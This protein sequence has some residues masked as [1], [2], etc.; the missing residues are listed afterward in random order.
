MEPRHPASVVQH[1][2]EE[3]RRPGEKPVELVDVDLVRRTKSGD[4]GAFEEL[5]N[6]Y[7][8]R[9][10]NIVYNLVCDENE[11]ADLTQEVFVRVYTSIGNLRV[12]EAFF[13]WVRTVAVNLCRDFMRRR[14]PRAGSLD[15][16]LQLDDGE[17]GRDLPDPSAGPEKTLLGADRQRAVRQAVASLSDDHRAVVVLHHLEGLDVKEIARQLGCAVGT[18]K[19]RL[20]RAR[21]E[22]RRKL[23]PWVD[24]AQ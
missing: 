7:Q 15:A 9:V 11:A 14:P 20:A 13:T 5:F 24:A 12:E 22:L 8:K 18:V 6:R 19:S 16:N 21:D 1:E 17:V 3:M 4:V 10:Y 23:G 2:N